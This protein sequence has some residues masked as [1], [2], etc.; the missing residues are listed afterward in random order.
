[1]KNKRNYLIGRGFANSLFAAILA[2]MIT[3][4]S[5]VV[6]GII[7]GNYLGGAALSA[8]GLST[9]VF[10]V[11]DS[12]F[13]LIF[14]GAVSKASVDL[15]HGDRD[16][17]NG[18]L[19]S[20]MFV[21]YIVSAVTSITLFLFL[22]IIS[23][24]MIPA[25][26]TVRTYFFQYASIL[27]LFRLAS[28]F[29]IPL[30]RF[31]RALGY[32]NA[33]TLSLLIAN[34]GNLVFDLI[35]VRLF[36]WG[37]IGCALATICG[38]ILAIPVIIFYYKKISVMRL[39]NP[40]PW[41]SVFIKENIITALPG[42]SGNLLNST[43]GFTLNGIVLT[44]YGTG[45]ISI[46]T[47]GMQVLTLSG[48]A[49][50]GLRK[51]MLLLGGV[52]YG[53]KDYEGLFLVYRR[54]LL[55]TIISIGLVSV[56]LIGFPGGI[57][58]LYGCCD[59]EMLAFQE[60]GL[61]YFSLFMMPLYLSF[62]YSSLYQIIKHY[63]LSLV[64]AIAPIVLL[65]GM[66]GISNYCIPTFF[67]WSFGCAGWGAFLLLMFFAYNKAKRDQNCH[68]PSLIPQKNAFE[69]YLLTLPY[70]MEHF[71]DT[72]D[73]IRVFCAK[74]GIAKPRAEHVVL[75]CEEMAQNIIMYAKQKLS[76][77]FEIRICL[78]TT[79]SITCKDDGIPFNPILSD[80]EKA[81]LF[82]QKIMKNIGRSIISANMYHTSYSYICG[83]NVTRCSLE[84]E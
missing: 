54:V 39:C 59:A 82:E 24:W 47:I 21:G 76:G 55:W 1:M 48:V 56:V 8:I 51:T 38:W 43:L 25:D 60:N 6:D 4:L 17:L 35:F 73:R 22:P 32:P 68:F 34:I 29:F 46:V 67:W 16:V 14:D 30:T 10:M 9:P 71:D 52:F 5:A 78:T 45:G 40:I 15:G 79:I 65:M 42:V 53:E 66:I 20:A 81:E 11:L 19:S 80:K 70:S 28:N 83:Q 77:Y 84:N 7:T 69:S 23:K 36:N 44:L 26:E 50:F 12:F 72:M 27:I 61:R 49:V 41:I 75:F 3:N 2:S 13:D 33:T 64:G 31:F 57:I 62:V 63:Q 37:I 58:K 74:N 18:R